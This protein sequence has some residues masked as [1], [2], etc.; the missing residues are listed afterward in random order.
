MSKLA[1]LALAALLGSAVTGV[2]AAQPPIAAGP[3]PADPAMAARLASGLDG[4]CAGFLAKPTASTTA[5]EA[6]AKRAGY[7]V[8]APDPYGSVGQAIE[9]APP[10]RAFSAALS[11]QADTPRVEVYLTTTPTACQLR[12]KGD[13]AAWTTFLS[14]MP[15]HGGTLVAAAQI[16]PD[17]RYSHEVYKG[18]IRGLPRGYTTFVNRWVGP[19]AP[20]NGVW[21]AIN[22]LPDTGVPTP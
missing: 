6:L 14:S 21:T 4:L 2:A 17:T 19:E 8:G 3:G 16:A 11:E 22:V 9:G 15:S 20:R 5:V 12:V 18:G 10:A 13:A 7:T 1:R